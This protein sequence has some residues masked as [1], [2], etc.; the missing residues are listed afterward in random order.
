MKV[1]PRFVLCFLVLYFATATASAVTINEPLGPIWIFQP[2]ENLGPVVNTSGYE[3][4]PAISSDGLTLVFSSDRPG[5]QNNGRDLWQS[6]RASLDG[7]WTE[8]TNLGTNVNSGLKESGPDLSS[9]GLTLFFDRDDG[10][11]DLYQST[12]STPTSLWGPAIPIAGVNSNVA[13][14]GPAISADGLTLIFMSNRPSSLGSYDFWQTTRAS[15][16]APWNSPSNLGAPVN[17]ANWESSPSLSPDALSLAWSVDRSGNVGGADIRLSSRDT[18]S[19]PWNTPTR[20]S[21]AVNYEV[22][23]ASPEFSGDGRTILFRSDR[24]GGY[25]GRDIWSTTAIPAVGYT[26][27]SEIPVGM[28]SYNGSG[29][30]M[31]FATTII[32]ETSGEE[33]QVGVFTSERPRLR[34]RSIEAETT[35]LPVDLSDLEDVEFA[36]D[37]RNSAA[38]W[39]DEDYVRVTLSNGTTTHTVLELHG[40]TAVEDAL[41]DVEGVWR[42]YR[43]DIPDDWTEATLIIASY[44]DSSSGAEIFDFD[45]IA[46]FGTPV[47]EP[48][49]VT[50]LVFGLLGLAA[51]GRRRRL[52]NAQD[53]EKTK[54][55][56]TFQGERTCFGL[57]RLP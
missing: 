5:S 32:A 57:N 18:A 53:E 23:E 30:E 17:S 22:F 41:D 13:D 33:R 29:L 11:P 9:D 43:A 39:E 55:G 27:F 16:V 3:S 35:F 46:F 21:A 44:S 54:R 31:G 48:T 4:A 50:L 45:D 10:D 56:R 24:P 51:F 2:P 14:S 15:T 12:R 26:R 6:T 38:S 49:T 7:P 25:G 36:I 8:P 47:P 19:S 40:R 52:R 37:V 28:R 42:N 1:L 34:M 20:L